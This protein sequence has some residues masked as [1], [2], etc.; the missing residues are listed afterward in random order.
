MAYYLQVGGGG[1]AAVILA[2]EASELIVRV[3]A[4][5]RSIRAVGI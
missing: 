3:K 4:V 1:L 5:T 2:Y